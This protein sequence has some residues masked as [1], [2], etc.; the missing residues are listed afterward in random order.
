MTLKKYQFHWPG[1]AYV[2]EFYGENEQEARTA[3]RN[4]LGVKR[5]PNNTAV[6]KADPESERIIAEQRE[7]DSAIYRKAGIVDVY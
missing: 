4:W 5:L 1:L 6:W 2:A 3:A 7:R